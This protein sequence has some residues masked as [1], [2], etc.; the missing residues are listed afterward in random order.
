MAR[1]ECHKVVPTDLSLDAL[2]YLNF[3]FAS[4]DL[5]SYTIVTMNNKTPSNLFKDATNVKSIK[6]KIKVFISYPGTDD[7]GG[8]A[9]DTANYILLLQTLRKTFD[10][11]DNDFDLTF[12]AP[13][14]Y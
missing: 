10:A 2:I 6:S 5:N 13:S 8:N 3:A 7:R 1:K 11:S 14:S 12:T 9:E 4:I